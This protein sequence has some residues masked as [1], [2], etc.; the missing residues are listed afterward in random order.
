MATRLGA[1]QKP[2]GKAWLKQFSREALLRSLICYALCSWLEIALMTVRTS[3]DGG[4]LRKY[5]H[6]TKAG[7]G[8]LEDF[9]AEWREVMQIYRFV[10]KGG[11]KDA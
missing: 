6:I 4:R 7:L 10:T 5:Y 8:R 2:A 11:E 1:D 3:E 9:K